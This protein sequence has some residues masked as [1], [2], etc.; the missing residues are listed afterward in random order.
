MTSVSRSTSGELAGVLIDT[1]L[2]VYDVVIT[3]H[4]VVE[5]GVPETFAAA[6]DLDFMSVKSPLLSASFFVRGLPDRLKGH[7]VEAPP[8]LRLATGEADLPGWLSLGEIPG[9]EIAFGA[10]LASSG[11]PRS[12]GAMSNATSSPDST[13]RV[14]ARSAVTSS[15]G[16]TVC[17]AACSPTS[18][19]PLPLTLRP[20][21]GWLVT[22]GR[23][24][25]WSAMSC[26]QPC[27]RSP[28]MRTGP[29]PAPLSRLDPRR[30]G[31]SRQFQRGCALWPAVRV[32]GR[33][34]TRRR[35]PRTR[36][37]AAGP[38]LPWHP[39]LSTRLP[40][41]RKRRSCRAAR[42][43]ARGGGPA[44]VR[45]VELPASPNDR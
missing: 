22:G 41:V 13:S 3:E 6:R 29:R 40:H 2:P 11:R 27:A 44:G 35:H 8:E 42:N 14:G 25:R 37:W 16:P 12:S 36:R 18:A 26:E 9:R 17:I 20:D 34:G 21:D 19:G 32:V 23:S 10:P 31:L 4:L 39:Q 24:D 38:L 5:A 43:S 7:Q 28:T 1:Y 15:Y 33:P 45:P 30:R